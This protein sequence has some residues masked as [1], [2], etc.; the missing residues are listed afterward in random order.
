MTS[1]FTTRIIKR[2]SAMGVADKI[3]KIVLQAQGAANSLHLFSDK[4]FAAPSNKVTEMDQ[5]FAR[6]S[7]AAQTTSDFIDLSIGVPKVRWFDTK[8]DGAFGNIS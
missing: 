5:F 8:T 1:P 3:P 7:H 4:V 2:L 6:A